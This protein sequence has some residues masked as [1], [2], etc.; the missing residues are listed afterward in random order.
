MG[1]RVS[2]VGR[3]DRVGMG[4]RV[5]WVGRVDGVDGVRGGRAC[6]VEWVDRVDGEGWVKW[7]DGEK[8]LEFE[9][10]FDVG[11]GEGEE[12]ELFE[13]AGGGAWFIIAF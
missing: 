1:D 7:G 5:S 2:W 13:V 9:G 3:V 10:V 6:R 12:A 4:D 8:C 11:N